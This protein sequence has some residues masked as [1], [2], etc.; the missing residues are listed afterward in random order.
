MLGVYLVPRGVSGPEGVW[1]G[2]VVWR[3]GGGRVW[4]RGCYTPHPQNFFF[5]FF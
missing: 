1:S 5:D 4:S 2:G 3:G